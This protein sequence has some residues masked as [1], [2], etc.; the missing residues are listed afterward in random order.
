VN[1]VIAAHIRLVCPSWIFTLATLFEPPDYA[2]FAMREFASST[3][4]V[5]YCEL[6]ATR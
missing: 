6:I 1:T 4:I 2:N 5:V 3:W